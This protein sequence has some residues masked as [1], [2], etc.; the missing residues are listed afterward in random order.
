MTTELTILIVFIYLIGL[1]A[2]I[3]GFNPFNNLW[4][5]IPHCLL[6]LIA[7][8]ILIPIKLGILLYNKQ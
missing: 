1:G 4:K 3:K 5:E 8:P 2:T 6:F 7:T